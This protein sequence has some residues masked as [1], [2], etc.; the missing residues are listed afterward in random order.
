MG[1]ADQSHL[2]CQYFWMEWIVPV[3]LLMVRYD[4][5]CPVGGGISQCDRQRISVEPFPAQC[6]ANIADGE[7][8][9]NQQLQEMHPRLVEC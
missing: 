4:D 7:S 5:R 3:L 1:S 2:D 6:W 9:L 8:T